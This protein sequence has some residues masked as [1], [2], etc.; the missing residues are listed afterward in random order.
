[1]SRAVALADYLGACRVRLKRRSGARGAAALALG[2]LVVTGLF[3]WVFV[4]F[5][6]AEGWVVATRLVLYM[7]LIAGAGYLIWR[8]LTDRAAARAVETVVPDF[9]G[10]L[11]TWRDA[12]V[13]GDDSPMLTLL[14]R[15]TESIART[16]SPASVIPTRDV[17]LPAAAAIALS[18][19][20]LFLAAGVSPWQLA[21]QR[22]W[23]GELFTASAP[24]ITVEPGDTVVPRGADVVVEAE[25][26]GF[27][28][29]NMELHA[30][31]E[32]AR[33]WETAPMSRLGEG[34]YGFVFVGVTERVEY[35]VGAAGLNSSRHVIHV[36]DL[37]KVTE[38]ALRYTFPDWTGLPE[39]ERHHHRNHR[40]ATDRSADRG[41]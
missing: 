19:A 8:P 18:A 1:M 24:R 4:T 16:R 22:L 39:A 40:P 21:A 34:R 36:A 26:S 12:T 37:P 29:R 38:V 2:A 9:D 25:A 33:D 30:A 17:A 23:T 35:Y 5:V 11:A 14:T 15:E 10:R 20:V 31:F 41:E 3:A 32:E 13:R 28:P 7:A 6:P 27:M